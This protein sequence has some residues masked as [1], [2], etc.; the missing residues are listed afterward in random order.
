[1]VCVRCLRD[2]AHRVAQAPDG[3]GSWEIYRCDTCNYTWR[4][5]EEDDLTLIAHRDEEFQLDRVAVL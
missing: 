5:S 1:M 2:T 3:S 4:S